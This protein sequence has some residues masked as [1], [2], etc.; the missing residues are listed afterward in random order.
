MQNKP[1]GKV[2][3]GILLPQIR[4][5]ASWH[6][7]TPTSPATWERG[8]GERSNSRCVMGLETYVQTEKGHSDYG[9]SR[10]SH[11]K[12]VSKYKPIVW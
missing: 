9:L 4:G 7:I 10:P 1:I 2:V 3:G 8:S 12:H 5:W 11:V 6:L